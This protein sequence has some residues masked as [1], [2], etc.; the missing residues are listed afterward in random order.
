VVIDD[1]HAQMMILLNR[2]APKVLKE[3]TGSVSDVSSDVLVGNNV[4]YGIVSFSES[5]HPLLQGID[6]SESARLVT[7]DRVLNVVLETFREHGF[8]QDNYILDF[9]CDF[10]RNRGAMMHGQFQMLEGLI[11]GSKAITIAR[12][13]ECVRECS[14]QTLS[15]EEV[16]EWLV[17]L[18]ERCVAADIKYEYATE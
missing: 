14:G 5:R 17:A 10:I 11:K 4:E 8:N 9:D 15:C 16:E 3:T 1:D 18:I 13:P 7:T 6:E 2:L 12:E